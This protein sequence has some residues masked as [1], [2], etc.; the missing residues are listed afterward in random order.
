MSYEN[1]RRVSYSYPAISFATL[2]TRTFRTPKGMRGR[3]GFASL[4]VTTNFVGTTTP[5]ALQVGDGVTANKYLDLAAGT[6]AAPTQAGSG[7]A[8]NDLASGLKTVPAAASPLPYLEADTV[9][10]VTFVA[11]VGG[12][13]AGVAD[14]LIMVDYF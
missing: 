4:A 7:V 2:T 10:T 5:A 6:A 11:G 12:T 3:V 1:P 8:A 13:P 14:S 9:Y